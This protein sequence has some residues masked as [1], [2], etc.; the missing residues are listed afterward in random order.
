MKPPSTVLA[1]SGMLHVTYLVYIDSITFFNFSGYNSHFV[2]GWH[3]KLNA[4]ISRPHP[5]IYQLV[6]VI[7]GQQALTDLAAVQLDPGS[8]PPRWKEIVTVLVYQNEMKRG[9]NSLN[10]EYIT[11]SARARKEESITSLFE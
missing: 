9:I 7:K 3:R 1:Q 11:S 8:Q 2:E 4:V 6:D 10:L 5:N